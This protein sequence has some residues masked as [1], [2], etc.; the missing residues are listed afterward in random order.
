MFAIR[1][2]S[3]GWYIPDR[4]LNRGY[5]WDEPREFAPPR[6]FRRR[7]DAQVALWWW[8]K[9]PCREHQ[10]QDFEGNW[11]SCLMWDSMRPPRDP[12]DFEVV[13]Y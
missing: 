13:P 5:T 10:Y 12:M 7:Q 9:G 2:K 8:L 4:L 3:T 6:T 1:Q 11:D